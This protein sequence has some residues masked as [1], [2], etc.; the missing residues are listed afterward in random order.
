MDTVMFDRIITGYANKCAEVVEELRVLYPENRIDFLSYGKIATAMKKRFEAEQLPEIE[1]M[2]GMGRGAF[3]TGRQPGH[4]VP[5]LLDLCV[6]TW[7]NEL[8]GADIASLKYPTHKSDVPAIVEEVMT[9]NE[10]FRVDSAPTPEKDE[11]EAAETAPAK[12]T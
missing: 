8:Y 10:P 3:F 11:E 5:M 9:F 1:T 2:V 6:L 12:A 7:L 4:A